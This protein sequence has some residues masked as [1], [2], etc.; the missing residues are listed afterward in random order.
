M[1]IRRAVANQ[2][3]ALKRAGIRSEGVC[4][5]LCLRWVR[6]ALNGS[7]NDQTVYDI[8]DYGVIENAHV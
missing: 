6:A 7:L 4:H 2:G 5:A 3:A 1:G 8:T